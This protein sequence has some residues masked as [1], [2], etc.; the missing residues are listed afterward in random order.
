LKRPPKKASSVAPRDI[1]L[2]EPAPALGDT[3]QNSFPIIG[4]GASAGGLEAF[5]QLLQHI[6][7]DTGAAFVLVQHLAPTHESILPALL[8]RSTAMP[9]AET[10]DGVRIEPDHVYVIPAHMDLAITDGHLQ[11][12]PRTT[13][14]ERHMPIDLFFRTLAQVKAGKGGRSGPLGD[15]LRRHPGARGDQGRRR[16]LLHTGPS[17]RRV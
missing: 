11:L 16:P 12:L 7:A 5:R 6:P 15:R 14:P 3:P 2:P 4:V 17:V 1:A 13:P 10:K 9:V 8:A